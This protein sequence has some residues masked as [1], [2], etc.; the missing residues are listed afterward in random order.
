MRHQNDWMRPMKDEDGSQSGHA[1]PLVVLQR[2][3][4][5]EDPQSIIMRPQNSGNWLWSLDRLAGASA[6]CF[7]PLRAHT[8]SGGFGKRHGKSAYGSRC[9]FPRTP[10]LPLS[11]PAGRF[12]FG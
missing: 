5:D 4:K 3:W 6:A 8:P 12:S 7:G 1:Q 9:P 10:A 11:H 2:P